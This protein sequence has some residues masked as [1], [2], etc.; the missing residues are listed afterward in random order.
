MEEIEIW[1]DLPGYEC[2]YQ[3]SSRGQIRSKDRVVYGYMTIRNKDTKRRLSSVTLKQSKAHGYSY[4][5]LSKDGRHKK[6]RIH[7]AVLLAFVGPCPGELFA[8]H[9][10]GIKDDNRIENL[11]YDT[12]KSNSFDRVVHGTHVEGERIG[13]SKLKE[14][15]VKEIRECKTNKEARDRFGVS[16]ATVYQIQNGIRWKHV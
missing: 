16:K 10:N 5:T 8:C 9:N 14:W 3:V 15:Q 4:V 2:L 12:P 6:I 1:K 7:K 13:T 11:R